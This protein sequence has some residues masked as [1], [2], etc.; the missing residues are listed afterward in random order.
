MTTEYIQIIVGTGV[1]AVGLGYIGS[2]FWRGKSSSR[3]DELEAETT[4][5]E[6]LKNQIDGF[7][8]MVDDQNIKIVDMGKEIAGLRATIEEKDKTIQRYLEILQNRNPE[9]EKFMSDISGTMKLIEGFMEKINEHMT[10]QD[11]DLK[12]EAT[13]SKQ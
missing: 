5:T 12:I 1:I 11:H 3:K 9:L 13:V 8:G 10:K 7:K 6:Y 2:Q 4:L